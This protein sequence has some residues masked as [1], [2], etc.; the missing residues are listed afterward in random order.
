LTDVHQD[1]TRARLA[2]IVQSS[3][4]AIIS[5][6][7]TGVVKTWNRGAERIFG[8]A[9]EEVIGRSITIII[10]TERLA[11]E[12]EVLRQICS[13]HS[14]EHFETVRRAKDGRSIDISL[15]VSPIFDD[16]GRIIGASKIARDITDQKRLQREAAQASRL[17]DEFLATLSHELRTP[18]NAVLG[19]AVLL[20]EQTLAPEQQQKAAVAIRRN[21]EALAR[22][23]DDLLDTSRIISGKM[24]LQLG[25]C[26][27][28]E[29]TRDALDVVRPALQGKALHLD[30]SLD[31]S[32]RV[33]G[34]CDRLRQVLWNLL[35]NAI[36]FTPRGGV[37]TVAVD[38]G[39][40]RVRFRVRDT[41]IGIAAP[42]LPY[43]FQRFWQVETSPTREQGGLGLGLA[44]SRYL[45]EL[46]GGTITADSA[47]AGLGAEFRVELPAAQD[48]SADG[49]S[50]ANLLTSDRADDEEAERRHV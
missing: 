32:A 27:L 31:G 40:G 9:P 39:D 1:D 14:V 48:L 8:Y 42:S 19:Y 35:T 47:G 49:T 17:K 18:L 28:G 26:D 50:A 45:V 34:D 37:I 43:I 16:D 15:T 2:A 20:G 29:L 46:H 30:L 44:L 4:D 6:D 23:V 12:T 41:G 22:L 33:V 36:K 5:K 7:L 21:A 13:G 11:E 24:H 38:R 25:V 10:P 3:D